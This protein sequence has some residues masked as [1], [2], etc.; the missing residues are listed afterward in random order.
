[1][2]SQHPH[3]GSGGA[4]Y[5]RER[6]IEEHRHREEMAYREMKHQEELA[7]RDQERDARER[8]DRERERDVNDRFQNPPDTAALVPSLSTSLLHRESLAR[9]IAR[10][11]FWQTTM[12][13]RLPDTSA[14][15]RPR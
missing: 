3:G 8:S 6:E 2:N 5:D 11:A 12:A 4:P 7:R 9:Y 15:T 10:A 13:T 1:M 14:G